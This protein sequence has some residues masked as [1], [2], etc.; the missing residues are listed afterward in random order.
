MIRGLAS[1]VYPGAVAADAPAVVLNGLAACTLIDPA[2]AISNQALA[3]GTIFAVQAQ[4]F[5]PG[6]VTTCGF[7]IGT[8]EVGGTAG[9]NLIGC[10][11][12]DGQTQLAVSGDLSSAGTVGNWTGTGTKA[13]PMALTL[14]NA[15]YVWML[16]LAVW[17][18]TAPAIRAAGSSAGAANIGA[19]SPVRV[20]VQATAQTALPATFNPAALT[21]G[22]GMAIGLGLW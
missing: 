5:K 11:T 10:Y 1:P 8:A 7:N 6:P 9:E 17:A 12:A 21:V 20:G 4:V 3:S 15:P 18:T 13:T 14:P 16:L 19:V 22:G 2:V